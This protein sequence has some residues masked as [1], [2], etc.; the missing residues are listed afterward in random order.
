[1]GEWLERVAETDPA[2]ALDLALKAAEYAI[3]K[4]SRVDMPGGRGP[5]LEDLI[6][7]SHGNPFV[8]VTGVPQSE[9]KPGQECQQAHEQ[10]AQPPAPRSIPQPEPPPLRLRPDTYN[11]INEQPV[12][13]T[14]YDHVRQDRFDSP[15]SNEVDGPY[16][17][18]DRNTR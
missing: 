12:I 16:N 3:P 14:G 6:V 1:M 5:T 17:P 10:P 2:K 9:A 7:G 8:V 4:L 13:S 15:R 11:S 18:L